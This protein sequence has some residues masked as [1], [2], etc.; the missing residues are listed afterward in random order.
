MTV[1]RP[2]V[3]MFGA[4]RLSGIGSEEASR[5]YREGGI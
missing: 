4:H 5:G 3:D 1:Y 2:G